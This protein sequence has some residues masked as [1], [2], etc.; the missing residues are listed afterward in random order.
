MVVV[1]GT[2]GK[3]ENS[4]VKKEKWQS[5]LKCTLPLLQCQFIFILLLF[6]L[7]KQVA[8]GSMF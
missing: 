5:L 3:S 6:V 1:V 2:I 4:S 8:R 7:A